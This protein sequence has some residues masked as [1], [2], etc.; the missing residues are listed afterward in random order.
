A[1]IWRADIV[2][3]ANHLLVNLDGGRAAD[4]AGSAVRRSDWTENCICS[5]R[6]H[7][8]VRRRTV[9][10]VVIGDYTKLIGSQGDIAYDQL[11]VGMTRRNDIKEVTDVNAAQGNVAAISDTYYIRN[12][13]RIT[14]PT[15]RAGLADAN[16]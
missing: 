10:V 8:V 4:W 2:R 11:T 15:A 9:C 16:L 14:V 7:C 1:E 3:E 13:C 5:H 6:D 12:D